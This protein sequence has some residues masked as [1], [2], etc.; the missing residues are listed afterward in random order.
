[1]CD[2]GASINVM[3]LSIYK[4]LNTDHLKETCV[5]I[6][7]ADRSVVHPEGVLEDILV[8]VNELIFPADFYII[9]MEDNN[10]ANS[11]D[12]LL[13]RPFLSTV[14]IK[15]DVRSGILTMEF[16]REVVK[17]NVYEAMNR[18]SMISNVSNIDIID[19]LIDLHLE[20]HDEDELCTVLCRS[21]NFDAMEELEEWITFKESVRETVAHMEALQLRK[22]PGS[23]VGTQ[24][25]SELFEVRISRQRKYLTDSSGTGGSREDDVY[26]SIWHVHLQTDAVRTLLC[27]S[28]VSKVNGFYK[29]FVKDFS[30]IA[31]L[32]CNLLQK[33]KEF[34]FDQSSYKEP[35][36]MS[37]YRLIFGK[38]CHLPVELE[39]KASWAVKQCNMELEAAVEVKSEESGKIFKVNG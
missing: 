31:Q 19:P 11:S 27:T 2:L 33:D 8:K 15:I 24:T 30:K 25:T 28:H 14:Q 1:M 17:F 6:Q 4:V 13:G 16:D 3:P 38:L 26:M 7:F 23:R 18:S 20:Y 21:L 32:L 36:S 9:D 34:E 22:N 37:P 39:H 12:I 35:I 5:I 10:S 29:Q